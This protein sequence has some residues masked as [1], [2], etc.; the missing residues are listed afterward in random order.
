MDLH[1]ISKED[2]RNSDLS[3]LLQTEK[4]LRNEMVMLRLNSYKEPA[5]RGSRYGTLRKQLARVLTQ[6]TA[7]SRAAQV[8]ES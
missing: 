1:K 7:L 2:I 8:K 3:Q 5:G 6:R 4:D